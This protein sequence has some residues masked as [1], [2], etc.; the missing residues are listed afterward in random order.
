MKLLKNNFKIIIGCLLMLSVSLNIYAE[1][2]KQIIDFELKT[3]DGQT[4]KTSVIRQDKVLV[5]AFIRTSCGWSN[6]MMKE[7]KEIAATNESKEVAMIMV[8]FLDHPEKVKKFAK[9]HK[10]KQPVLIDEKATVAKQYQIT[11]SAVIIVADKNGKIIR[12]GFYILKA[13]LQKEID[14]ANNK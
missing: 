3:T 14:K 2:I 12:N 10:L 9:R 6:A 5:L 8:D 1:P 7:L 4:T 11:N 13:D